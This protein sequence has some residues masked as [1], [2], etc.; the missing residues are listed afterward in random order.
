L[1][2]VPEKFDAALKINPVAGK[3]AIETGPA[4]KTFQVVFENE[5]FDILTEES[6]AQNDEKN[7][8][9]AP[10]NFP[11]LKTANTGFLKDALNEN[12][13]RI[14][15]ADKTSST[16][17]LLIYKLPQ[18][19]NWQVIGKFKDS[20]AA[21]TALNKFIDHLTKINIGSEG[22]HLIEHLLLKPP[23]SSRFFG[24][25]FFDEKGHLLCRQNDWLTFSER[26]KILTAIGK[27]TTLT[28]AGDYAGVAKYLEGLCDINMDHGD[29]KE[30]FVR[31]SVLYYS[32]KNN[33]EQVEKIFRR[34][35]RNLQ[36]FN[37]PGNFVFPRMQS[38][39][40]VTDNNIVPEDFFNFRITVAF[41]SWPARFQDPVFR[42]F[43]EK[44]FV[45][46]SPAYM[47]FNFKWLDI[48]EMS[49]FEKKY[50]QWQEAMNTFKFS[51]QC[52]DD[53]GELV[54]FLY[55]EDKK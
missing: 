11:G 48:T 34:L 52:I 32:G 53:A 38:V 29:G 47:R 17:Q 54:S 12:H 49:A 24:F 44:L 39:V 19:K 10:L 8:E 23:L 41:P 30:N 1:G 9:Q 15:P 5:V 4:E 18:D 2:D 7:S 13:Y 25:N 36:I 40:R 43:T 33:K 16:Q 14:I 37:K 31:P 45:K 20:I 6:N 22:F 3:K 27:A 21:N 42:I 28:E 50:F 35:I 55:E 26:D 46:N 51:A